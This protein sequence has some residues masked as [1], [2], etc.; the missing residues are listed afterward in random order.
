MS[1]TTE[2]SRS[3]EFSEFETFQ[4]KDSD[5][6]LAEMSPATHQRTLAAIKRELTVHGLEE[7]DSGAD[8]FVTYYS[9]GPEGTGGGSTNPN[10]GYAAD[11]PTSFMSREQGAIVVDLWRAA[12][13]KLVWR[14]EVVKVLS[15]DPESNLSK[16]DSGIAKMF[17][18]FPPGS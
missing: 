14:S 3:A 16:I 7:I 6:S 12:D 9:R 8:L 5:M 1:V 10:L 17:Q 15:S 2:Y 18:D 4:Y 13:N 11:F